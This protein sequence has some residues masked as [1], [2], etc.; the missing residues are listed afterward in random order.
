MHDHCFLST[1][2]IQTQLTWQRS[3]D[4]NGNP[5]LAIVVD[6]LRSMAKAKPVLGA[7]RV[8]PPDYRCVIAAWAA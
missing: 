3:E 5:F 1:T 8:Y 7:F 6:P 4:P 2:D